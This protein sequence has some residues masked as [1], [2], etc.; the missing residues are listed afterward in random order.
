MGSDNEGVLVGGRVGCAD[1][2]IVGDDHVG[3]VE[4][5]MLGELV[6]GDNVG[7]MV[8]YAVG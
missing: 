1:G 2:D 3:R 5:G 4:G 8:G 7:D 6:V